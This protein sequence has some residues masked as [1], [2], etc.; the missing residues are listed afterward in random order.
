MH[1]RRIAPTSHWEP[2]LAKTVVVAH[3]ARH[4]VGAREGSIFEGEGVAQSERA[5]R[6]RLCE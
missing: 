2:R 5:F 1:A 6:T 4:G 3:G